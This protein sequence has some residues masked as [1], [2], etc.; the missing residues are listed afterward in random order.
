MADLRDSGRIAI[1]LG[2]GLTLDAKIGDLTNP[3]L[4]I[5]GAAAM[6]GSESR[7]VDGPWFE[8]R[9]SD[10]YAIYWYRREAKSWRYSLISSGWRGV[11]ES[12]DWFD[13]FDEVDE[14]VDQEPLP[15]T[16]TVVGGELLDGRVT[17]G[18]WLSLRL[19][20]DDQ[21]PLWTFNTATD[22]QVGAHLLLAKARLGFN[23]LEFLD[24]L[25]GFGGLD[26][27]GDDPEPR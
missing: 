17:L 9:V 21:T 16:G 6:W 3:S 22:L 19:G 20:S 11:W 14:P 25:L 23:L 27:A 12:L 5:A 1:G 7:D 8:A 24:F 15:E 26:I 4:G 18:R 2:P 13:A 10:P